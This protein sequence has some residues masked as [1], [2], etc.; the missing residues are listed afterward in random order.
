MKLRSLFVAGMLV[1]LLLVGQ[2]PANKLSGSPAPAQGEAVESIF[3]E[4]SALLISRAAQYGVTID[5]AQAKL[6]QLDESAA[7]IVPVT[8]F[9]LTNLGLIGL[10]EVGGPFIVRDTQLPGGLYRLEVG[11]DVASRNLILYLRDE[12]GTRVIGIPASQVK[13]ISPSRSSA[14]QA[15]DSQTEAF[16]NLIGP[17]LIFNVVLKRR[18]P[19]VKEIDLCLGYMMPFRSSYLSVGWCF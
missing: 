19:F 5:A 16:S 11:G 2:A 8:S 9:S 3:N 7:V 6:F 14:A 13:P 1:L 17:N 4:M 18:A 10:L 15:E 12:A